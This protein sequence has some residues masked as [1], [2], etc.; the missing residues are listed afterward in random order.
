MTSWR[1]Q[2]QLCLFVFLGWGGGRLE[3]QKV[4]VI[5]GVDHFQQENSLF[6]LFHSFFFGGGGNKQI[7]CW[8]NVE[9]VYRDSR[10]MRP[11][12]PPFRSTTTAYDVFLWSKFPVYALCIHNMNI[13]VVNVTISSSQIMYV[14][15]VLKGLPERS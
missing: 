10:Q 5:S 4:R 15:S 7:N 14:C 12:A 2:H 11:R 9:S 6:F 8:A 13:D 3:P 1:H